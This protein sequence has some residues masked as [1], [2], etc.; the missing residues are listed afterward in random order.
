M[1][2]DATVFMIAPMSTEGVI[3]SSG[4]LPRYS[5]IDTYHMTASV[6]DLAIRRIIAVGGTLDRIAAID[7]F[8]WPD[9]VVSE[10]NP[11]GDYKLAQLVRSNMALYNYTKAFKTPCIPAKT[12]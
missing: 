11:D 12:V 9:P 1:I 4:V 3:L 6:I 10:S 5:D 7:N 8:C 2:S